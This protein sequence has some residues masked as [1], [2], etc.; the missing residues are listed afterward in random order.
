VFWNFLLAHFLADYPLQNSW[1]VANKNRLSALML[2]AG[3]HF[4]VLLVVI[5]PAWLE[6][7]P[8][9]FMLAAIHFL[10]DYGKIAL[11]TTKPDWVT[12]PYLVDQCLHYLSLAAVAWWIGQTRG[13]ITLF[14]DPVIAILVTGY[15]LATYV[16]AI[17]EKV[18]TTSQPEYRQELASGFW[19]RIAA[20]ALLLT[21]LLGFLY[22]GLPGKAW[23]IQGAALPYLSGNYARRALFTDLLVTAGAW[24]FIIGAYWLTAGSL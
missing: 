4:A 22:P 16:W 3:I 2:H 18:L 19:P 15:L 7:W 13:S 20:R 14:L 8:F 5:S 9:C 1:M 10:I 11:S 12:L 17:S 23:S 6:L 24:L 21:G